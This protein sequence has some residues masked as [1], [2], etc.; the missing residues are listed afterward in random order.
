MARSRRTGRHF[1]HAGIRRIGREWMSTPRPALDDRGDTPVQGS[2]FPDVNRDVGDGNEE[3]RAGQA[4]GKLEIS[5]ETLHNNGWLRYETTQHWLALYPAAHKVFS[6]ALSRNKSNVKCL[7]QIE[8]P[9][10]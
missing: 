2:L 1:R 7:L 6:E 10:G 3:S 5:E 8:G 4:K 9:N